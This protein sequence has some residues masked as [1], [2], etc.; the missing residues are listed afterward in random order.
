MGS[1]I[2]QEEAHPSPS[3]VYTKWLDTHKDLSFQHFDDCLL[4]L[5]PASLH[6]IRPCG[7]QSA[8]VTFSKNSFLYAMTL[9]I[10]DQ[11]SQ[12]HRVTTRHSL[13][14]DATIDPFPYRQ[15]R[16]ASLL[17]HHIVRSQSRDVR[18]TDDGRRSTV[19][20]LPPVALQI[21]PSAPPPQLPAPPNLRIAPPPLTHPDHFHDSEGRKRSY[22]AMASQ[23]LSEGSSSPTSIGQGDG[24]NN[25]CLCQPEPKVPRP[26]N[27]KTSSEQSGYV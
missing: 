17:D 2:F 7:I 13:L 4:A 9:S 3:Y 23:E 15:S 20:H 16:T 22:Q 19:H 24:T 14:N 25:F 26:R 11:P 21:A 27:G 6:S 10:S 18:M 12:W 8:A 5:R 1:C